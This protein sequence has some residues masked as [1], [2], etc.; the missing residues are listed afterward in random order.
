[1]VSVSLWCHKLFL[2]NIVLEAFFNPLPLLKR[3]LTQML[4]A[5][6]NNVPG[7]S[8]NEQP[9]EQAQYTVLTPKT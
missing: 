4:I 5:T 2:L 8:I 6:K 3:E 1:M 9:I 7:G